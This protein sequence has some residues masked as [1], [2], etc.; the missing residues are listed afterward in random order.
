ME[1]GGSRCVFRPRRSQD[2]QDLSEGR[3]R[4]RCW[5]CRAARELGYYLEE[6]RLTLYQPLRECD[7]A[8]SINGRRQIKNGALFV[9]MISANTQSRAEGYFAASGNSPPPSDH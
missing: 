4:P 6:D 5:I 9:P 1:R 7:R 8:G 3:V 2:S